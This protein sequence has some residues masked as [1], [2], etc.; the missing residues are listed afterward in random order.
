M[1]N[2]HPQAVPVEVITVSTANCILRVFGIL[3]F[4]EGEARRAG[5]DLQVDLD[6][7]PILVEHVFDVALSNAAGKVSNVDRA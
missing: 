1:C 5:G 2:L 7:P 6:D 3:E 4:D